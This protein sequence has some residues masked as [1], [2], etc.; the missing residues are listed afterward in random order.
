MADTQCGAIHPEWHKGHTVNL[1]FTT[2]AVMAV[3]EDCRAYA[4]VADT[5]KL[6]IPSRVKGAQKRDHKTSFHETRNA[7]FVNEL[8]NPNK[9]EEEEPPAP[10]P[11]TKKGAR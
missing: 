7:E 1:V 2:G 9:D 5:H 11:F 10:L 8:G 4:T 6:E 3:C